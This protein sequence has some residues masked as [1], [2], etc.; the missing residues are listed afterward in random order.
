MQCVKSCYLGH[1][2]LSQQIDMRETGINIIREMVIK[3]LCTL[4]LS[5]VLYMVAVHINEILRRL[6]YFSRYS[7]FRQS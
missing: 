4:V 6:L 2:A 3:S 5:E 1:F 7:H